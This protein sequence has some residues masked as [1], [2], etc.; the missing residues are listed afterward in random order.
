MV[1]GGV[2]AI[3]L[4]SR[5]AI[6]QPRLAKFLLTGGSKDRLIAHGQ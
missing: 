6:I 5:T 2:V 1:V 3:L 4:G